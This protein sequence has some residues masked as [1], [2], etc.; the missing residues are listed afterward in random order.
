[1][2]YDVPA[3]LIREKVKDYGTKKAIEGDFDI[4]CPIVLIEDV[5][6]TGSS[7]CEIIEILESQNIKIAQI[8]TILDR[9]QNGIERIQSLGYH[10]Q[11]LFT[12]SEFDDIIKL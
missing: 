10:V 1:M 2:L 12:L 3:V 4:D 6:T 9:E 11:S 8:L 7:V 5:I